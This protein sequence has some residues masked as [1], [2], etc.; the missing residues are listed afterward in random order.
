MKQARL[1]LSLND[2]GFWRVTLSL[3]LPI[4]L[5]NMLSA[6]FSLIDTLMVSQL[7]DIELSATGMAGQWTWLFNMMLFGIASGAAVFVSQ[8]W[9][10]GNVKGIHRATGIAIS[11]GLV[12]SLIF[13]LTGVI[14]P[15]KII[16]IFNK[17]PRV[18]E[19]GA[20]YLRYAAISY[21]AI[22]L[23][24]ILGSTLRSAEHPK[25][26][27]IVSG[28]C[29][30]LNAL[31]NY[32]LIFPAGL[33][34]KGAAIATA[35]SAWTGPILIIIISVVRKNILYAPIRDYLAFNLASL[36]E[37]FKKALPVIV[38]ETMWGAG[39]VAYNII[40]ANIGYEEYAAITIV[41]TFENFSFCFFLG[42]CTACCV[43]VGKSIGAGEIKE[44]V[45]NS[46]RFML[47]F[48]MV[49]A[50]IGGVVLLL[51]KPLVS[52]FNL[53]SNI[54]DYTIETAQWMLAMIGVWI[55]VRNIPY[56]TVVGIFRPGGD[57]SF[58]MIIELLVLWCFSVPM[59]YVAANVLHLPFLL[60]YAVMYLCEDIPKALIFIPY[61]RSGRWVKP[62]T[63]AGR[64]GLSKL[65]SDE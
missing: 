8:Y 19:Q 57:T 48:P 59:T 51:R 56:L 63:D 36:G 16:Y 58:G 27:M 14:I 24:N 43:M 28:I 37:F 64:E 13:L 25:L 47:I 39:T 38:N 35:I 53:G 32:L 15:D 1:P 46:K 29:A 2:R 62:V 3:A 33:G 40:F 7:G 26:P 20:L 50:I 60:V 31:V 45:R 42:L 4:A 5:Q 41:R 54:S 52:V 30:A 10:E 55:I 49:S 61:W 6:S 22:A 12:I 21:P 9:G 23:T 17:D 34:V 44:G 65:L 18:I 11:S